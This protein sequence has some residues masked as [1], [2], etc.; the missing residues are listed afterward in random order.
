MCVILKSFIRFLVDPY[1]EPLLWFIITT[2]ES[3]WGIFSIIKASRV[4]YFENSNIILFVV[5]SHDVDEHITKGI[6]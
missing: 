4:F 5:V 6:G 2:I 3:Y 1:Y